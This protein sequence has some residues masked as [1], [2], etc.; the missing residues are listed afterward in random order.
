MDFFNLGQFDGLS[1]A[2]IIRLILTDS[3]FGP[4]SAAFSIIGDLVT[5]IINPLSL[6]TNS[7]LG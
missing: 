4:L 2:Q 7:F 3:L 5:L 6:F 1:I